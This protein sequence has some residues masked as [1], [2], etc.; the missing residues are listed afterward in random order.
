[1]AGSVE[2]HGGEFHGI[3]RVPIRKLT[4]DELN[5]SAD[6]LKLVDQLRGK[7]SQQP[8][9]LSFLDQ[10]RQLIGRLRIPSTSDFN[11]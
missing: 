3:A 2:F 7:A 8:S 1:M 10:L 4:V 5:V 11:L 6:D 9:A